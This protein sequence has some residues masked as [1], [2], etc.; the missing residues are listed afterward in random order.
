MLKW[1]DE[2]E[3]IEAVSAVDYGLTASIWTRDVV[4]AHRTVSRIKAGLVWVNSSSD[5]FLALPFGGLKQSGLGREESIDELLAY[6]QVKF[7]SIS[8]DI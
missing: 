8:P 2:G 3:I 1:E 4:R 7:V 6:T 5:H